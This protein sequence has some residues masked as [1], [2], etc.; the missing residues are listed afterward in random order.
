MKLKE[1]E[2]QEFRKYLEEQLQSIPEEEKIKLN[3]NLLE[4]LIFYEN[5]GY[6][7]KTGEKIV[8]KI[9]FW[10]P[11]ILQKIDLSEIS[12]DEVLW[13]YRSLAELTISPKPSSKP[14]FKLKFDHSSDTDFTIDLTFSKTKENDPVTTPMDW[15]DKVINFSNTNAKI[16]FEK[17]IS[18][19]IGQT[20]SLFNCKFENVDLSESHLELCRKAVDCTFK[21]CNLTSKN[22]NKNGYYLMSD[23]ENCNF[24]DIT[25]EAEKFIEKFEESNLSNTGI[26]IVG[27]FETL[28]KR[29]LNTKE[30]IG[31]KI[32]YRQLENCYINGQRIKT[33]EENKKLQNEAL[34]KY[35]QFTIRMKK[36][37]DDAIKWRNF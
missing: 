20:P 12:F 26:H 28:K 13:D 33:P 6:N 2:I 27:D 22:L 30:S 11:Q 31:Q 16:D 18:I 7:P 29:S 25:I 37:I 35:E 10:T 24:Q 4:T 21:N 32:K 34:Q 19:E 36:S 23:F 17:A 5:Y 8:F 9:P 1:K 14:K 15:V 3:K